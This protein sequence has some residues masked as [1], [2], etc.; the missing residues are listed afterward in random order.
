[1]KKHLY[2]TFASCW[3]TEH[4]NTVWIYSDSH[5]SDVE[6]YEL[7]GLLKVPDD[8]VFAKEQGDSRPYDLYVEERI[9][10]LDEEQI[11]RINAKAGR[12]SCLIL[13]GDVGNIECVKKLKAK[14]KILIM[15]NH[16]KGASNYKRVVKSVWNDKYMLQ[17][18]VCHEPARYTKID[19]PYKPSKWTCDHCHTEFEEE[20]IKLEDNHLFDEVYEGPLMINDRVILSHEPTQVPEYMFNIHG[21]THALPYQYDDKHLNVC[22]EAIDYAPINML[23][24]F[25]NGLLKNTKT[26]HQTIIEDATERKAKRTRKESEL[27]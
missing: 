26:I 15:G 20:I 16:D 21:H 2:D 22:A 6:S 12:N 23:K 13:L 1:M 24:L 4:G 10:V 25:K 9:K 14:R 18:P 17:C 3:L 19:S 8:L 11:K 7:R 27:L 5:F